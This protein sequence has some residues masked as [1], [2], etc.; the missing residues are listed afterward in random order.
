[1]EGKADAADPKGSVYAT[2]HKPQAA[3]KQ[4]NIHVCVRVSATIN[5]VTQVEVIGGGN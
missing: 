5:I 2:C 4:T 3:L 1:M